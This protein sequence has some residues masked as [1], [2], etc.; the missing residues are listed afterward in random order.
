[1]YSHLFYLSF[2][3]TALG[4]YNLVWFISLGYT[5][6]IISMIIVTFILFFNKFH[7]VSFLQNFLLLIWGVRLF[8]FLFE[9][10]YAESYQ[11][12]PQSKNSVELNK[13]GLSKRLFIYIPCCF[14]YVIM[15]T[16]CLYSVFNDD[17]SVIHTSSIFGL[18]TMILGLILEYVAD[19]EKSNFK[20]QNP[21]QFCNVGTYKWVRCPNYLGEILVWVGSFITSLNFY[22][23]VF[24]WLWSSLGLLSIIYIMFHSTNRLDKSQ[25]LKYGKQEDYQKYCNST[26]IIF[27]FIP[28]YSLSWLFKS[29]WY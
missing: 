24:Q 25:K 11:N 20:N 28:M 6:S 18:I 12:S 19:K 8:Y 17:G 7:L 3:C 23:G 16:P 26:P 14:L 22:H 5:L 27:P 13:Q 15:Y 21:T 1:M 29:E 2:A 4:F 10:F 9:R